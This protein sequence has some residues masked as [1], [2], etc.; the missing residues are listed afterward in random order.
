MRA[1]S[2]LAGGS[3]R[4]ETIPSTRRRTDP[5]PR[6]RAQHHRGRE[7]ARPAT[8]A[9]LDGG[10]PATTIPDSALLLGVAA[11]LQERLHVIAA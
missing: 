5:A 1:S 6:W 9:V 8:A 11:A 3:W 4:R 7:P 10:R 2:I